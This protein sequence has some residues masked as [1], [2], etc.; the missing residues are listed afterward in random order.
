M[1]YFVRTAT[2]PLRLLP[3]VKEK[4]REVDKNQAFSSVATIDELVERSLSR[5][6]F[7]LLLLGS[8]AGLAL[9]LAGVGLY[10]LISYTTGQRTREIGIRMA[11]G[12]GR[13]D[14]L[15]VIVAEAMTLI[16]AGEV[17]GLLSS[18]ALTRLMES[19]LFGISTTDP[20]T[21]VVIALVLAAIPLVACY[22][23][24][25]RATRVDPMVAL[26]YE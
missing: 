14:V 26:R 16:L 25:R 21:F 23:P 17:V 20:L 1:T 4:I 15:K 13:R 3:A 18:L 19:L 7:N 9:T 8:F 11:F 12:A 2:D 10:G 24:A 5:R 22:I 6:R